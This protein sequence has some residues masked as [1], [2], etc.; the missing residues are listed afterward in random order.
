MK[1]TAEPTLLRCPT[2]GA[3]PTPGGKSGIIPLWPNEAPGAVGK[4]EKDIP[5]VSYYPAPPSVRSGATMIFCPGGSYQE[6]AEPSGKEMALWLNQYGID[7][8]VLKYRLAPSGYHYPTMFQDVTRAMRLVRTRAAEWGIDPKKI[9]IMGTS[10]GGHLA[11]TLLTHFD[12]GN[13]QADDPVERQGSRPD[14]GI[15][16]CPVITMREDTHQLTKANLLGP[17]PS[18]D[19][20]ALLSNDL[21]VTSET[22]PCFI[23]HTYEDAQVKMENSLDFAAA[24][25]KAKVP[26]DF[27]IYEKGDHGAGVFDTGH[28]WTRDC[29]FW[30]KVHDFV[31]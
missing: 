10:A 27:H 31:K 7:G 11:S 19:L 3:R 22:P 21:H 26:F 1:L 23:W 5:S 6:L 18:P 2:F 16:C 9:G 29:L 12:S 20:F 13:P 4:E 8:F 14:V 17:N 25:R 15:L 30:L 24:L 28:P